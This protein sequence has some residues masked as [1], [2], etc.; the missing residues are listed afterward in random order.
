MA[1][2]L[3]TPSHYLNQYLSSKVFHGIYL[4]AISQEMVMNLIH[5]IFEDYSFK[6]TP[7]SPRSQFSQGSMGSRHKRRISW[8]IWIPQ[9]FLYLQ[10]H[11]LV[12]HFPLSTIS[13][14][15]YTHPSIQPALLPN[16]LA[17][18]LWLGYHVQVGALHCDKDST[19][20]NIKAL[21]SSSTTQNSF[22]LGSQKPSIL[23]FHK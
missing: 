5:N 9:I 19:T 13:R 2:C 18:Y 7:I 16:N 22:I 14:T 4:I 10:S 6:I 8:Y 17:I 21:Q 12:S 1:Y 11:E 23:S 3:T 15:S 20:E